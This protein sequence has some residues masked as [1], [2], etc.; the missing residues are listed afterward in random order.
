M[1][2]A[3]MSLYRAIVSEVHPNT[4]NV[5]VKIPHLLGASTSIA[6]AN[7]SFSE[8]GWT[9]DPSVG[10]QVIVAVEGTEFDKVY[11]MAIL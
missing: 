3:A 2:N 11:L 4:K 5:Y 10:D 6:V 7:P 9:W 8:Y 1:H